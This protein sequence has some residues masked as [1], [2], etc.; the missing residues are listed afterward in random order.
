MTDGYHYLKN[1]IKYFGLHDLLTFIGDS[2]GFV[3][4]QKIETPLLLTY[5][6]HDKE[7]VSLYG[8]S[9]N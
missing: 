7:G 3:F 5:A 2:L 9:Q 4:G 6:R 1:D 8:L